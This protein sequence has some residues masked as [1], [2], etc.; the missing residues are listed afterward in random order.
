M[1]ISV[2]AHNAKGEGYIFSGNC[3]SQAMDQ[4]EDWGAVRIEDELGGIYRKISGEMVFI[5]QRKARKA[6]KYGLI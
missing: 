5:C 3:S 2:L 4:A 1:K 6:K